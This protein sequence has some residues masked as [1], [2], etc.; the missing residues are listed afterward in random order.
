MSPRTVSASRSSGIS[1]SARSQLASAS[2][3]TAELAQ[4]DGAGDERG[5][6]VGL[7]RER[8][9]GGRQ[10]FGMPAEPVERI[11]AVVV[12]VG[13]VGRERDRPVEARERRLI[14][15]ERGQ[16]I[17]A[18]VVRRREVGRERER[19]GR[20][21]SAA[22]LVAAEILQHGAAIAPVVDRIRL[23]RERA[24]VALRPPPRAGRARPARRRGC[25]AGRRSGEPSAIARSKLASASSLRP[26][27][28]S[29]LP[30][31]PWMRACSGVERDAPCEGSRRRPRSGPARRRA[32]A[33]R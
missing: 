22:C 26:R 6:M 4:D 8:A 21:L 11:G 29:A 27:W 3:G 16:R 7:E 25:R 1:A 2:S 15:L 17:A 18:I 19:R 23:E 28:I 9:V 20:K 31:S 24:V 5:A 13:I 32:S 10:R 14:A 30:S 12:G 33:S